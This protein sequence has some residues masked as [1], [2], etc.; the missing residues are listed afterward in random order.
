MTRT[1][2]PRLGDGDICA[3][4][5]EVKAMDSADDE[6]FTHFEV[7]TDRRLL[8]LQ[9][10]HERRLKADPVHD[11]VTCFCCC[12]DCDKDYLRPEAAG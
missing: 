3:W 11:L 1:L 12:T 2:L 6:F 10:L 9:R 8:K 7:I 5:Q 4:I